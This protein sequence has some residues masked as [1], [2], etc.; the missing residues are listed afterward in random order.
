MLALEWD[1]F[2]QNLQEV[3]RDPAIDFFSDVTLACVEGQVKSH[4]L[5]LAASSPVFN[6]LLTKHPHPHPLIFLKGT[7][8]QDLQALLSFAYCGEVELEQERLE[9]FLK[10]GE[11]LQ[12]KGL[13]KDGVGEIPLHPIDSDTAHIEK[14]TAGQTRLAAGKSEASEHG[15]N[16]HTVQNTVKSKGKKSRPLDLSS[17]ASLTLR[18]SPAAL[19][20]PSGMQSLQDSAV[21][22]SINANPNISLRSGGY[23]TQG[24]PRGV[25]SREK[26]NHVTGKMDGFTIEDE[27]VDSNSSS[28]LENNNS[29]QAQDCDK[30]TVC[31]DSFPGNLADFLAVEDDSKTS[32]S[33]TSMLKCTLCG[34]TGDT[35]NKQR[36]LLHVESA[37]FPGTFIHTC[38]FCD[39]TTKTMAALKYH[40]SNCN[41]RF[42][43]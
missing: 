22:A 27:K 12:V 34:K 4:K 6:D 24:V 26:E 36:L 32:S 43:K 14:D 16:Q 11:E 13:T 20:A 1:L 5:V 33:K 35:R 10:A 3:L 19:L 17:S 8:L 28:A 18:V 42:F 7:R 30:I 38:K 15:N 25:V 23:S 2:G 29:S 37:H 41:N 21:P 31:G 9:S 40:M 39:K